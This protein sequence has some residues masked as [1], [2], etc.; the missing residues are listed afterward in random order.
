[1][2]ISNELLG[3]LACPLCKNN[4]EYSEIEDKLTCTGCARIYDIRDDIPIM[5]VEDADIDTTLF[6]T[7]HP[8]IPEQRRSNPL[9]APDDSAFTATYFPWSVIMNEGTLKRALLYFDKIYLLAPNR[10][11]LDNLLEEFA[12]DSPRSELRSPTFNTELRKNVVSFYGRIKP[13]M[14]AG[15]IVPI[16]SN[17]VLSDS[18][19]GKQVQDLSFDDAINYDLAMIDPDLSYSVQSIDSDLVASE[20]N[21]ESVAI[22][23]WRTTEARKE[24]QSVLDRVEQYICRLPIHAQLM[25]RNTIKLP[26]V[27]IRSVLINA[28]LLCIQQS[29][30]TP[31]TD[32]PVNLRIIMNKYNRICDSQINE[33]AK[34]NL[35]AM[36]SFVAKSNTKSG[37]LTNFMLELLVPNLDYMNLEDSLELRERFSDHL[38]L[39]RLRMRTL[40]LEVKGTIADV[41]FY[42]HCQRII[43]KD[44]VPAVLDLQKKIKFSK[45][46]LLAGFTKNMLSLKP[47]VPFIISAFAPLPLYAAA[48]V[49]GGI[50]TLETALE[51]YVERRSLVYDN[52]LAYLLDINS[53]GI[54]IDQSFWGRS[55]ALTSTFN[56]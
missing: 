54:K 23:Y 44:I 55:E 12:K 15:V 51:L 20:D 24:Y 9:Q 7:L 25:M 41:E 3:I 1:M 49:A 35:K 37:M 34:E 16:D 4:L 2:A 26:D 13:L 56:V 11:V 31:L 5:L 33:K 39:L 45:L 30:S 52:A 19:F 14:D 36:L 22:Q 17:D 38:Q 40:S 27:V 6:K 8:Q 43:Q 47:T 10:D 29:G 50:I 53:Q 18:T 28:S 46:K 42:E 32:N 21:M 48:L